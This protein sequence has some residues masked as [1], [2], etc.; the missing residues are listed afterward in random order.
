MENYTFDAPWQNQQLMKRLDDAALD[1][2]FLKARPF[3]AWQP[4][5]VALPA[6][7]FAFDAAKVDAAFFPGSEPAAAVA[8]ADFDAACRGI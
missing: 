2:F 3:N 7:R 4:G 1:I 8:A 5:P 6:L